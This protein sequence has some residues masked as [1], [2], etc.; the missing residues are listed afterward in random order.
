MLRMVILSNSSPAETSTR[1]GLP[2]AFR[3]ASLRTSSAIRAKTASQ[4]PSVFWRNRRMVGYQGVSVRFSSQRQSA[5]VERA[6][7]MGTARA[8]A[9]CAAAVSAV[10]TRSRF[11]I[12]APVST[13][14]PVS[15][16]SAS[17][18][19]V[20]EMRPVRERIWSTPSPFW[21]LYSC[22]PGTA[23]SGAKA[24]SGT[25]RCRSHLWCGLPCQ[26]MPTL[27]D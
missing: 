27:K 24:A 1:T 12:T 18:S 6:S 4:S 22:T 2:S 23:A 16:S 5:M 19:S 15:A 9:R 10:M 14:A 7:Q 20:T 11:F 8:P 21:R 25:E 17:D 26:A 13:N 3:A